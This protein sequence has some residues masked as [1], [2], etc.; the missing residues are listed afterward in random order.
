MAIKYLSIVFIILS[1]VSCYD[2][3]EGCLDILAANYDVTSDDGCADCC[4]YPMLRLKI[5]Q[6]AGDSLFRLSDTLINDLGQSYKIEDVR[7]Y[8]SD[9]SLFQDE[10]NLRIR[11]NIMNENNSVNIPNDMKI[12]RGTDIEIEIGTI[13]SYGAFDSLT[14]NFGLSSI[15]TE[16]IFVNLPT[17]HVL[18]KNSM[19]KDTL[20]RIAQFTMRFKR[21]SPIKDTVAQTIY[22][23]QRPDFPRIRR[24]TTITTVKGSPII[25]PI[26]TDYA[27]L[28]KNIDMNLT[29][30]TLS[31]L[32]VKN[33]NKMI[34]VK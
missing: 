23:T 7:F 2:R 16:N 25:F 12:V 32:I 14:F 4:T 10:A 6:M 26:K 19:L 15:I 17:N 27:V 31:K 29:T 13:R 1:I 33:L 8:L 11:E 5:S 21:I 3:K 9:F 30:D 34:I 28:F 24:D 20:N 18:Q 22:V